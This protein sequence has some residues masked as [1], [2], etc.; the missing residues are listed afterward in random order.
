MEELLKNANEFLDS[1]ND[2]FIKERY[3]VAVSDFFKTI[4][5]LSDYL[6]Y[7][8]IKSLPKNHNDR[9]HYLKLY[10]GDIYSHVSFLFKTYTNS[11]NLRLNKGD[12]EKVRDY[13]NE[14]KNIITNKK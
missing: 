13:A 10:F 14:L 2:N 9:F 4:A 5:I 8:K 7:T 12:A 11:Y 3:N 1:G 6:I